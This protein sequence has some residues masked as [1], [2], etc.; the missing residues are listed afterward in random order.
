MAEDIPRQATIAAIR[1][2]RSKGHSIREIKETLSVSKGFILNVLHE[3]KGRCEAC[4]A[5]FYLSRR[6]ARFCSHDCWVEH[7][8]GPGH[9]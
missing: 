2:L 6:D 5:M 7:L 8:K 9:E 1:L 4:D 3:I